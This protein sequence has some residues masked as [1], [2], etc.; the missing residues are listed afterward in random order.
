MR[1]LLAGGGGAIGVPLTRLLLEAGH[2][3][4]ALT[5]SDRSHDRLRA[6]GAEPITADVLDQESLRSALRGVRADAVVHQLTALRKPPVSHR[7]MRQTD[8]LRTDGTR[9]L[10]RAAEQ[11]GAV[12]FL[13][14][15]MLFGYGY[16]DSGGRVRTEDDAFAPPGRGRFE[17]HL[18]AMRVN[19]DLVLRSAA[20]DGIALRYGLFY[21]VGAGDQDLVDGLRRRRLPVLRGAGPLS[22]I[23]LDDAATATVAALVSGEGGEAYNVVDDEP[24]SWTTLMTELAGALGAPRP[25]ALPRWALAALP[26][27]RAVLQGGVCAANLKARTKLHWSPAVPTYR[28]GI[29][30]IAA[31][32]R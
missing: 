8:R 16:G 3:V 10:V 30:R 7:D 5:R 12:R 15:S 19:E 17:E 22:W 20:F 6:L 23:Y 27:A 25:R 4:V 9:N 31:A 18:A 24:V 14:Q 29:G 26:Y 13:T 21:G 11:V 32:H 2:D 1:V 28:D